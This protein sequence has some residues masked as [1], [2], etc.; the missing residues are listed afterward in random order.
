[1]LCLLAL[2]WIH[3]VVTGG[4]RIGSGILAVSNRDAGRLALEFLLLGALRWLLAVP[5]RLFN[6]RPQQNRP[7]RAITRIPGTCPW[8]LVLAIVVLT[9]VLVWTAGWYGTIT[10]HPTGVADRDQ[11]LARSITK[12]LEYLQGRWDAGWYA[13][14]ALYGY[15]WDPAT[16]HVQQRVAFFPGYPLMM[17]GVGAVADSIASALGVPDALGDHPGVRIESL[18]ALVSAVLFIV[19][20][21]LLWHLARSDLGEHRAWVVVLL[22][23][24]WPF[25][26]FFSA[27]YTESLY[28]LGLVG[29]FYFQRTGRWALAV[30]CGCIVGITRQTG[31]LMCLPLFC[32]ALSR[33]REDGSRN[34]ALW[35]AV[36]PLAGASLYWL[37]L[38]ET[39]GDPFLW[40]TAQGAWST[41]DRVAQWNGVHSF[42]QYITLYPYDVVNQLAV[43]V[44]AVLVWRSRHVSRA[45]FVLGVIALALPVWMSVAPLGRMTAPIFPMYLGLASVLTT[46]TQVIGVLVVALTLQVIA[47]SAFYGWQPLY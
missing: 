1:M 33:P 11:A 6:L 18:G 39:F 42:V 38:W 10:A 2:A 5:T 19:A 28:L 9:R 30:W 35:T 21:R 24:C 7:D 25:S 20:L 22:A 37:Y 13:S 14:I 4:G 26:Y 46:R 34:S 45:Y 15:Q 12:P 17:R 43:A 32:E 16:P 36:A 40:V 23:A 41:V 29:A 3:S 8:S 27:P 47:A 31:V 44:A